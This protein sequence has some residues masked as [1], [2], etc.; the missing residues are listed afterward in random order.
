MPTTCLVADGMQ[1][2]RMIGRADVANSVGGL[3]AKDLPYGRW[4]VIYSAVGGRFGF[5]SIVE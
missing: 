4:H 2:G 1:M 5:R 3:H